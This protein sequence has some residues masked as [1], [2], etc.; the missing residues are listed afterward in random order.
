MLLQYDRLF[1][2][3]LI[4]AGTAPTPWE[5]GMEVSAKSAGKNGLDEELGRLLA[6]DPAAM[7]D[8]FS[9]WNRLRSAAPVHY[10]GDAYLFSRNQAVKKLIDDPRGGHNA[11]LRG[12]RAEAARARLSADQKIAF[13]EVSAFEAMYMSRTDGAVHDRL[14]RIAQRTFTPGR[15]AQIRE[16]IQVSADRLLDDLAREPVVDMMRFAYRLPLLI[17]GDMLGIPERDLDMV[18]GWSS[19]LGRNRGGTEPAALMEAHQAMGEFRA[20]VE[21]MIVDLR[22]RPRKADDI[23]LVGDLLDANQGEILSEVELTAMIV[24]LLFAGHETTTNLIGSGLLALLQN[25]QWNR[26]CA[27]PTLAPKATEEILRFVSPVQWVGRSVNETMEIDGQTLVEGDTMLLMVAAANRDPEAFTDPDVLDIGRAAA[28]N[29][30]AFGMG[31][32]FCLG[33]PLARMEGVTAFTTLSRRFPNLR[34]AS[35]GA[36]RWQGNAMLRGLAE[37]PI[38]LNPGKG[39]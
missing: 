11:K 2:E 29:H 39:V 23:S 16:V 3:I 4:L 27:E 18:H 31:S 35:D 38:E 24:V 37:L 25:D 9:L 34:L 32:H 30:L 6:S 1:G 21:K 15:I 7:V 33:S 28:R 13:D 17:I 12:K 20:Y 14:R 5:D 26:F 10:F 19:K 36:T 8:P 22:A